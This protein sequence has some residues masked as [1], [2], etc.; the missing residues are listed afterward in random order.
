MDST[1]P[2]HEILKRLETKLDKTTEKLE[3]NIKEI[4]MTQMSHYEE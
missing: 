2:M 4:K 1:K 3:K